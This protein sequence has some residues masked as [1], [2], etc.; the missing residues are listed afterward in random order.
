MIPMHRHSA[1]VTILL[2]IVVFMGRLSPALGEELVFSTHP[3]ANPA[4]IHKTFQPLIEYLSRETGV[5]IR[6]KIAPSYTAHVTAVGQGKADLA[7][8]GP[9]PYVRIKDKFGGVELLARLQMTDDISDKVVVVCKT[10]ASFTSLADLRGKTFAF[11]DPQSYGSHY[12]PRWLLRNSG[13]PVSTLAAYDYVKSHD[14]VI[15]SVLHGDFDAGGV[16]LDVYRKYADRPLR[17]LAGPF[18]T[19]P[20]ALIC[21][22]SLPQALQDKLRQSLLALRDREVLARI[23]PA[24]QR[25]EKVTDSD[26]NQARRVINAIE[27]R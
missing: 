14:N 9:A 23:D 26:F 5:A 13:V 17:V 21:R 6:I 2:F 19:P 16:R 1:K 4:A 25:F 15:L 12:L 27:A 3:F 7:F 18:L 22:A 11:G 10:S 24:M 20:H 8:V